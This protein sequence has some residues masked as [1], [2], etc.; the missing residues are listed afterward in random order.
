MEKRNKE[1]GMAKMLEH[2]FGKWA[3]L[4]TPP[5]G[6]SATLLVV[7]LQCPFC[8]VTKSNSKK[9]ERLE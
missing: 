8:T 6:N 3:C 5:G 9:W 2:H 7:Q 1:A 4:L